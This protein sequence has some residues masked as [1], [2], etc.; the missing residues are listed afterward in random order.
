[1]GS[2]LPLPSPLGTVSK[3]EDCEE[4]CAGCGC[5]ANGCNDVA[6]SK[7]EAF[8]ERRADP[9]EVGINFKSSTR[10]GPAR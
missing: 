10:Q 8:S 1:M 7:V 3:T 6:K 9:R 5:D 4:K 2:Q